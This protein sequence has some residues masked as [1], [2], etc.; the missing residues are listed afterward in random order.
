MAI[1]KKKELTEHQ[2]KILSSMPDDAYRFP[3]PL[4]SQSYRKLER[5]GFAESELMLAKQNNIKCESEYRR[6]FKRTADGRAECL[7]VEPK[8]TEA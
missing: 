6:A 3:G 8:K 7:A 2:K 5:M 4:E 1:D